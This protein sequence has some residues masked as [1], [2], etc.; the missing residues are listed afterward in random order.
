MSN[1][2]HTQKGYSARTD[3]PVEVGP[4]RGLGS[5]GTLA[6]PVAQSEL[7]VQ[8]AEYKRSASERKKSGDDLF[9]EI[10]ADGR[11]GGRAAGGEEEETGEGREERR[12]KKQG[13]QLLSG[14]RNLPRYALGATYPSNICIA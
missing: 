11:E 4:S 6:R 9:S 3:S 7:A 12:A 10:F 13:L 5:F 1:L 14:S 2:H 8:A